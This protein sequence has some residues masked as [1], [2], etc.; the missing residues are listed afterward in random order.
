MSARDSKVFLGCT[1][2][3]FVSSRQWLTTLGNQQIFWTRRV[4]AD[5]RRVK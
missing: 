3:R 4:C 2:G 1:I 5:M